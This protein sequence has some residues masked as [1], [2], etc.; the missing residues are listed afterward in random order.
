MVT[1]PLCGTVVA[2]AV[3]GYRG[4]GQVVNEQ[5][6]ITT[7]G[8]IPRTA[9]SALR[10]KARRSFVTMSTH[11]FVCEDRRARGEVQSQADARA[12]QTHVLLTSC[13]VC[14][15]NFPFS[16]DYRIRQAVTFAC[17]SSADQQGAPANALLLTKA[18]ICE[19]T[20]SQCVTV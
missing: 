20:E 1:L 9:S 16:P 12:T 5:M 10:D 19:T 11:R 13:F 8:P 7:Y 6:V 18:T 2:W 17:T 15:C 14:F 3:T 4:N